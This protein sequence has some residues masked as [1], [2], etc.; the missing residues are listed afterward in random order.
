MY[1][2]TNRFFK[3]T[4]TTCPNKWWLSVYFILT[5]ETRRCPLFI[6]RCWTRYWKHL[7]YVICEVGS[8]PVYE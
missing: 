7:L 2:V 3:E 5:I 6:H 4:T 1:M 8:T